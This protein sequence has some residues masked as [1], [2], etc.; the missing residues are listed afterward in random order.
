MARLGIIS[1]THDH[2]PH[3][4]EAL[5][6]IRAELILNPGEAYGWVS[7]RATVVVLDPVALDV[8]VVELKA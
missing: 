3:I 5:N 1:D 4:R 7:G 6:G 2:R 8:E